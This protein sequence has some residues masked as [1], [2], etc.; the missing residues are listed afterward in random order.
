MFN[1]SISVFK[2]I[3]IVWS[4]YCSSFNSLETRCPFNPV[5]IICA[6]EPA[7]PQNLEEPSP[8]GFIMA[9]AQ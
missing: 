9:G 7:A 3:V 1:H 5:D 2:P 8:E 6:K 4:E